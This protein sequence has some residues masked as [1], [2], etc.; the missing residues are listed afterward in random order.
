MRWSSNLFASWPAGLIWLFRAGGNVRS[1]PLHVGML[2]HRNLRR[3]S[4]AKRVQF[5]FATGYFA[6]VLIIF[7]LR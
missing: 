5:L 7:P 3:P 1:T 2:K 4:L 6:Y